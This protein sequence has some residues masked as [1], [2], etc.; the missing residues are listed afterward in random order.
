MTAGASRVQAV[1]RASP[2]RTQA[3]AEASDFK[4]TST[5]EDGV[6]FMKAVAAASPIVHYTVYGKTYEG[7]D[8][9]MAVVGTGLK[10]ASPAAVKASGKLRVHIQGN[11]HA[12]EVEGKEAAQVLLRELET[13]GA[14]LE[15]TGF[16]E[17]EIERLLQGDDQIIA[18]LLGVL[19]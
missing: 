2:E 7:R 6:K 13:L 19:E 11:I 10:D 14:D 18:D 3:L 15:L 8:M 5:H 1:P 9:P 12:G 17:E 16:S 4:S